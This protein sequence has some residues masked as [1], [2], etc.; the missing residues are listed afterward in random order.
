[1]T[2]ALPGP[3]RRSLRG[4]RQAQGTLNENALTANRC[5]LERREPSPRKSVTAA[6]RRQAACRRSESGR[7]HSEQFED[8]RHLATGDC[9]SRSCHVILRDVSGVLCLTDSRPAAGRP[10]V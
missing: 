3:P 7:Q 9:L 10:A 5:N 8:A 2:T 4:P 6:P 1:V